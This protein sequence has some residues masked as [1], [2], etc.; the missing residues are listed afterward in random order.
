MLQVITAPEADSECEI[1]A[2]AP[3]WNKIDKKINA[4]EREIKN[5]V[6]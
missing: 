5:N 2:S 4:I 1:G 6:W 3:S